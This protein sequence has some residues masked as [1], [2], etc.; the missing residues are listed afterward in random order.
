MFGGATPVHGP[1]VMKPLELGQKEPGLAALHHGSKRDLA[2]RVQN[3]FLV[4]GLV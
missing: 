1:A 2:S 3:H 4:Q